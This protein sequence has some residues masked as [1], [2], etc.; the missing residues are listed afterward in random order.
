MSYYEDDV[1]VLD[2]EGI[3]IKDY[4]YPGNK[5][6]IA[7]SSIRDVSSIE[8]GLLTGRHRLVGLGFRRPR[9]FFHWDRQRSSKSQAISL[10]LG[11]FFHVVVTPDDHNAA[12]AVIDEHRLKTPHG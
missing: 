5:R 8:L 3:T 7:Y 4:W 9:H 11:G 1:L 10:D 6:T 12:L 2:P